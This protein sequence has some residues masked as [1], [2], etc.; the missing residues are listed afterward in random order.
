MNE[1]VAR[2][3]SLELMEISE[4]AYL[5]TINNDGFPETRAMLNLR[6]EKQFPKLVKLFDN[7]QN[8]FLLYFTTNSSSQKVEQIGNNP[9]VS[10]YFCQAAHGA[11]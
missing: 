9:K 2:Q 1:T 4:A 5:T 11:D 6:R 7:Y 3:L 8:E 10:V